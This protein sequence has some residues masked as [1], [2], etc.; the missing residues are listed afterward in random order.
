[1]KKTAA[2][3]ILKGEHWIHTPPTLLIAVRERLLEFFGD[4]TSLLMHQYDL[5]LDVIQVLDGG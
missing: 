2:V 5:A 1:M 3:V 4:K